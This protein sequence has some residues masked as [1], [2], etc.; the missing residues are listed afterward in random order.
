MAN[1]E[2]EQNKTLAPQGEQSASINLHEENLEALLNALSGSG[3]P[4]LAPREAVPPPAAPAAAPAFA[5]TAP[6]VAAPA[7]KTATE[8]QISTPVAAEP[9]AGEKEPA[10]AQ[11][12]EEAKTVEASAPPIAPPS[13]PS[14]VAP[15]TAPAAAAVQQDM[16][17]KL[18]LLSSIK[19]R[20]AITARPEMIEGTA[21]Q[22]E[23]SSAVQA[24]K[25]SQPSISRTPEPAKEIAP[26][27]TSEATQARVEEKPALPAKKVWT[28][29]SSARP[30]EARQE[31]ARQ[32]EAPREEKAVREQKLR[33]EERSRPEEKQET[34]EEAPRA[35]VRQRRE[36]A[37]KPSATTDLP[38]FL[39]SS[40]VAQEL[41]SLEALQ[42]EEASAKT[43][44]FL[45]SKAGM[46]VIGGGVAVAAL[47]AYLLLGHGSKPENSAKAGSTGSAQTADATTVVPSITDGKSVDTTST[48]AAAPNP[49]TQPT[50]LTPP[51]FAAA[52][53]KPGAVATSTAIPQV[54]Q[55]V[56]PPQS[57][58][59]ETPKTTAR[60]FAAPPPA[61]RPVSATIT[62]APPALTPTATAPAVVAL[63]TR[64]AP[65]PPPPGARAGAPQA[66]APAQ[67]TSTSGQPAQIT[68]PG[69]AQATRLARQVLPVYPALAKTARVQG[70]VR[71]RVTVG[72]DGAVK[73]LTPLGGPLPLV[74]AA[75]DA[76]RQWHYQPTLVDGKPVEVVTEID[77]AFAL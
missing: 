49:G 7:E 10:M 61:A 77:V 21:Q 57:P 40:A 42:A 56:A 59:A 54:P 18:A 20:R 3:A 46:G 34:I 69:K 6:V 74:Q 14:A 70:T 32:E 63:P 64:I 33:R 52:Q 8:V 55:Q 68:V 73:S 24:E 15:Q 45:T 26:T 25:P 30:G 65:L 35:E 17:S 39:G 1:V 43:P 53:P 44:S 19:Q 41:P 72:I 9:V 60:K 29:P 27:P 58:V 71:F 76:V 50:A 4:A 48:N 38:S 12:V 75:T 37:P 28:S 62:D 66:A 2:T 23:P 5:T 47:A 11:R 31:G 67:A 36:T 22:A 51:Q 16:S 13:A